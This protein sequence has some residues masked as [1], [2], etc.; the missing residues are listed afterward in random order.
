MPRLDWYV[1][2]PSSRIAGLC[3]SIVRGEPYNTCQLGCVYCYA[4]WYRGPH[5]EPRPIPGLRRLIRELA[6]A[7]RESGILLP[8]RIATLSDPF[9]PVEARWK[10]ALAG[11]EEASRRGVPVVLNT[12]LPP[13]SRRH[14]MV[15]RDLAGQGLLLAQVTLTSTLES[16]P[17]VSRLE[18]GSPGPEGRLAAASYYASIGA[19]L[20]VR[21]QPL[22]PGVEAWLD[23][24]LDYTVEAGAR[25]VIVEF[26]RVEEPLAESLAA[27]APAWD[28]G[29]E[30]YATVEAGLLHPPLPYRLRV[31][32]M[33]SV[34]AWRRGLAF[35]TCKE[36]LFHTHHPL[37]LDCCGFT[38]FEGPVARRPHLLDVYLE[39]L[40]SPLPAGEA[41]ERACSRDPLL[42]CGE[43][44]DTLPRWLSR[45]LRLHERRLE[46][47]LS[48]PDLLGKLAPSL[49]LVE[50]RIRAIPPLIPG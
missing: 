14:H 29:W 9:Q 41:L 36:G 7:Q 1:I 35:Q 39:A 4:R 32:A 23:R 20:M 33:A 12:R 46:R 30:P 10:A 15:L 43:R 50:G 48:R 25:G 6:R 44:L 24:L 49:R 18:P 42:L 27:L 34:E 28:P 5:G 38:L 2:A 8:V 47:I 22:I 19:P 13:P 3:H 37:R 16:W 45:S 11:L 21:L 31:A 17:L 40:E 26:L